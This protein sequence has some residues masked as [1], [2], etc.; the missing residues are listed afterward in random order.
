MSIKWDHA[1]E[2]V[3]VECGCGRRL[4]GTGVVNAKDIEALQMANGWRQEQRK[5]GWRNI[6]DRCLNKR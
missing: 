1:R 5:T 3:V 6:C 4:A 2:E